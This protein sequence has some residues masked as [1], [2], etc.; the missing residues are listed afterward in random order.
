M[1]NT[2]DGGSLNSIRCKEVSDWFTI[3]S[4]KGA[5]STIK[6]IDPSLPRLTKQRKCA[7][8]LRYS[9]K[10]DVNERNGESR[11]ILYQQI[12]QRRARKEKNWTAS[13]SDDVSV[14]HKS[15][16]QRNKSGFSVD[17]RILYDTLS[18]SGHEKHLDAKRHKENDLRLDE[19][20][21]RYWK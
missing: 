4:Y 16:E 5:H 20:I 7:V 19:H 3:K 13:R 1:K 21:L 2:W 14:N 12:V 8:F 17:V 9:S 15:Q 6:R 11:W 10:A 18:P